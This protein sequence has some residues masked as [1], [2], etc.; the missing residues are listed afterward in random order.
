MIVECPKCGKSMEE[1]FTFSKE[2]APG[3]LRWAAGKPDRSRW[4]GLRLKGRRQLVVSTYCCRGC[5]YLESYGR[6][7]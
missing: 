3:L 2:Q 7:E 6:P 5:G 1:G 4:T